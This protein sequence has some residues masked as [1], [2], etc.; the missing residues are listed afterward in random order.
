MRNQPL[1]GTQTHPLKPASR[2]VLARIRRATIPCQEV[3]QG[4]VDRLTRGPEPLAKIVQGPNP[5]PTTQKKQ[6]TINHLQITE[7]GIR[8]LESHV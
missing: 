2:T 1:W 3:N 5:Y 4:V 7:A 8:E 6:P